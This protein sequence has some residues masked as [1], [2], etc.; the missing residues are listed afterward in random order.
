MSRHIEK[1]RVPVRLALLGCAPVEG[2][3]SL[4]THA[5]LHDGPETLLERLNAKT[6]V[7]PFHRA[8]DDAFLLVVR[9][10]VEWLAAGP[11][12]APQLVRT[13]HFQHTREEHV[14]VRLA[15]G[16]SF[17]GILAFEMPHEFNRAS[18]FLNGDEDFFPLQT[19]QGTL[20]F[21][22]DRLLDVRIRSLA[23]RRHAA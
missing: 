6:R 16:A 21:H 3:L 13:A 18:D 20:L 19:T 23:T 15:G 4:A 22:K 9:S 17:D 12:V 10:Q 7:V 1:L 14:R 11:E 5:E 2:Y 8:E